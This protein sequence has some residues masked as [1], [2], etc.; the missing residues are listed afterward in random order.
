MKFLVIV[1]FWTDRVVQIINDSHFTV[2]ITLFKH[3]FWLTLDLELCVGKN[4]SNGSKWTT[5][6]KNRCNGTKWM[7]NKQLGVSRKFSRTRQ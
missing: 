3:H 7:K 5:V 2:N 6:G 1:Q 4:R